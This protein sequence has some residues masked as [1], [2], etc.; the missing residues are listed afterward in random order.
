MR[1]EIREHGEAMGG[2]MG[3]LVALAATLGGVGSPRLPQRA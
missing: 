2:V 3:R 1:R